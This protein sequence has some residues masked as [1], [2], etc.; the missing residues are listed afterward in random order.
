MMNV[1]KMCVVILAILLTSAINIRAQIPRSE[2][3]RPQF[4]RNEWANLNGEW[5][6]TFDFSESGLERG[7]F[8]SEGFDAKIVVPFCPES[9]LSGV[10]YKDF[11]NNIWYHRKIEI[12]E[13]WDGK[14]IK[15]NFGA[16][17]YTAEVYID[18]KFV[19]RHF[20]GSTSFSAD[21]TSF[22]EAGKKHNLVVYAH[23]D[24][25]SANQGA[26]KQ[27]L[28]CKSYG[29]NY[30]RTTGIWQTVWL[31]A[32]DQKGLQSAQVI[33][34]IDQSK[35]I[36][37]PRFYS[38]SG[39]N[40]NITIL[41]KGRK[42]G[43]TTVKA[44]NSSIAIIPV[45]KAKLWSP[46]NP[47]L[48]DVVYEVT[49]E[50]GQVLDKVQSYLGMRKVHI[51]GNKIYLNNKPFYHRLVLD[52]GFYPEGIW[53]APSDEDLIED[54]KLSMAAGFNGARLHQKVF[55][56][57]FYYHADRL[58]YI[59]WGE[60][61]SWGMDC[62]SEIT[63]RNFLSE[64]EDIVVRDR[65]HPS[66]LVWTPMN[67]AW[68]PDQVQYPRFVT[69]LYE[70]A[71]NL[72]PTRPVN[73]VSG[74][75]HIVTDIYTVHDYEQDGKR[76]K[77]ILY[78]EKGEFKQTPN[79]IN[80]GKNMNIGFNGLAHSLQFDFPK[81]TGG[82]P[83]LIDEFGGIKWTVDQQKNKGGSWGYG[84]APKTL[85][86]LYTRL[87]SQVDAI[88]S[89]KDQV[90]GY[91]YTQLTDVEQEQNGIYFYDRTTKFDMNKIKAIFSKT[92]E[93]K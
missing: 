48:Y 58:G 71:K 23:S 78:N 20:G 5:T 61:A 63:A 4:E 35:I 68:W 64:W 66:L 80:H 50:K 34:D 90:W 46:E 29:C 86:E 6:Y 87:E 79:H 47:F 75:V 76:L 52:Q 56:E 37:H 39:N 18:G 54:I 41:E 17:Y 28:Q 85:D 1:K 59:T 88:L 82:Q 77:N 12:P 36:I 43:K 42:I 9:K 38:E 72:D 89:L 67:E 22:V 26:G 7:L 25:R 45:K 62:N 91:C 30:T 55:E 83:Y 24:L 31:E 93:T 73:T 57:R 33:T 40:L 44:N 13:G 10:G 2:H 3:P 84:N 27:N 92:P 16:V 74:G 65:N 14:N 8:N 15:L 19:L 49:D 32:I 11:I 70:M 53:T 60:A 51:E 69:D 81:Y 21:I